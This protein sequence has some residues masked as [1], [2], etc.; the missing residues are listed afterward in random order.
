MMNFRTFTAAAALTLGTLALA[1]PAGATTYDSGSFSLTP[2]TS[3]TTDLNTTTAFDFSGS[4]IVTVPGVPN[5]DFGG[6]TFTLTSPTTTLDFTDYSTFDFVATLSTTGDIGTFTAT[7]VTST[8][9][10][11]YDVE[12][13]F[14]LGSF[15]DNIGGGTFSANEV[16]NLNQAGGEG[17]IIGMVGTFHAPAVAPPTGTPEP[18]TLAILGAGLAGIGA[19]RR[20]K[21]IKA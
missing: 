8:G 3:T 9:G 20:R 12:G 11:S 18:A 15:W 10:N 2:S 16:W 19:L 7:S 6:Q 1:A 13:S 21:A 17:N 4:T 5:N 14:V